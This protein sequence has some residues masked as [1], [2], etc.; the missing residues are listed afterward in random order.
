MFNK[1]KKQIEWTDKTAPKDSKLHFEFKIRL[2]KNKS[3]GVF[4][5]ETQEIGNFEG[6]DT[7]LLT[8]DGDKVSIKEELSEKLE[9]VYNKMCVLIDSNNSDFS[10]GFWKDKKIKEEETNL[11]L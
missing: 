5:S 10:E 8:S 2:L 9:E 4:S 6:K 3:E 1:K 11:P 7:L